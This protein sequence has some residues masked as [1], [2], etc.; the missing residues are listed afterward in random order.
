[1]FPPNKLTNSP[2]ML[3]NKDSHHHQHISHLTYHII[4][5]A[6]YHASPLKITKQQQSVINQHKYLEAMIRLL[7]QQH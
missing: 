4:K 1:M 3:D 2:K 5:K 6:I 7:K